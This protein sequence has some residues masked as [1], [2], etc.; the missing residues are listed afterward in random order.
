MLRGLCIMSLV[1]GLASCQSPARFAHAADGQADQVL[2][3]RICDGFLNRNHGVY[4]IPNCTDAFH[5]DPYYGLEF[6]K[7]KNRDMKW[8]LDVCDGK[9]HCRVMVIVQKDNEGLDLYDAITLMHVTDKKLFSWEPCD[10]H[11]CKGQEPR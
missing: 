9:P 2:E 1:V 6:T 3:M 10:L 7:L 4:R 11:G 5:E 8:L